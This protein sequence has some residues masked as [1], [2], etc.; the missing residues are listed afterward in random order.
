MLTGE[1]MPVEKKAGLKVFGATINKN[2][3]LKF[4]A[5]QVGE[6]TVLSQIIKLVEE[7]QGSKAPIQKLADKVSSVFVPIV[8][9]LALAAFG[10]WY[11]LA[12]KGFL[13]AFTTLIA[14][15]IIACPCA[16]GLATPTA[17]M[18]GTGIGAQNGILIKNAQALELANKAEVV[19]FDK[20][21]TLTQGKPQ[22]TDV[23][24]M[25]GFSE[26]KLLEISA[27]AE[28]H[29]EHPLA[30]A[31]IETT[32]AKKIP[33]LE[34]KQFEAIEGKGIKAQIG[35]DAVLIG[36]R[37]LMKENKIEIEK[38]MEEKIAE[39]ESS[40]KTTVMVAV[41]ERLS[42][43]LA[44]A[45]P[46]KPASKNAVL[47]LQKIGKTV[48][49][50]TGDNERTANAIAAQAGIEKVMAEVLPQQKS[51]KIKELQ[52][53]GKKVIMVGD[54]INDAPALAQADVGIALG[55]GTDIAI[56][57]GNIVLM[58]NDAVDVVRAIDLSRYTVRK[59]WENL[60]WAFVYNIVLIPVAM[61]ALFP[62]FGILLNPILAGAAMAFS[63]VSVTFNSL[64]MKYYK[65]IKV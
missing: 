46:L 56:E 44:I 10:F 54:G 25:Q 39:F 36:T 55:S 42:G 16:L 2:G 41:N 8:I 22:V 43:I 26:N 20:T 62:F 21:G 24:A 11:V 9:I 6:E 28:K 57:S 12:A 65:L 49:M 18:M 34:P 58:K 59:I 63:S 29:S 45:D 47:A 53:E 33:L 51:Q 14:V 60:G 1:S 23:I 61:G 5:T 37:K 52:K 15:L 35:K 3:V 17:I 27:S 38:S 4:K 32:K 48:W 13:F 7:A 19:V 30:L 50:I 31:I 40:A 64:R